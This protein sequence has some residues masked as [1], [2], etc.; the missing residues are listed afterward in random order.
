MADAGRAFL[1]GDSTSCDN[2]AVSCPFGS[3]AGKKRYS[4]RREPYYLVTMAMGKRK[5]ERQT[6]I[7]IPTSDLPTAASRPFY[8]RLN[9]LLRE[10][11][12]DDF[13][14]AQ[15]AC[16]YAE[17]MGRPGFE[18]TSA[19][20]RMC[21]KPTADRELAAWKDMV[22]EFCE[23]TQRIL[24]S[25]PEQVF[26]NVKRVSTARTPPRDGAEVT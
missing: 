3:S 22:S 14:D 4:V 11:G 2:I 6:T 5:R 19:V 25:A 10:Y 18:H 26:F 23:I 20:M 15:C 1:D 12:F 16:F 21:S 13:V 17:T 24:A 9:Q 8:R 7:W